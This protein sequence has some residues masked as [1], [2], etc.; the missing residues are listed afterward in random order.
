[1]K[2]VKVFENFQPEENWQ[3][4]FGSL[5]LEDFCLDY[6]ED[7]KTAE[8]EIGSSAYSH[9][10]D[11]NFTDYLEDEAV[12]DAGYEQWLNDIEAAVKAKYGEEATY[13]LT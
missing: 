4:R 8:V 5:S 1:M 9:Y 12:E 2:H 13:E 7:S 6:N 11:Q 3:S 10:M